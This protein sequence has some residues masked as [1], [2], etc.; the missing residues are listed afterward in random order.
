MK[1][2]HGFILAN[3]FTV[4]EFS[5]W[6]FGQHDPSVRLWSIAILAREQDGRPATET[7]PSNLD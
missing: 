6:L 4:N 3:L 5:L 7:V 2:M 1:R